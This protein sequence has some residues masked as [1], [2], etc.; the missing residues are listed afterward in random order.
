MVATPIG[1]LQDMSLRAVSI[2][3][4]ADRIICED[5]RVTG[6][7]L[8][9]FGIDASLVFYNDHSDEE[10]RQFILDELSAGKT[11][12]M[13]SDAGT[14]LI[15]DPGYKLVK[16][17]YENDI[18]V[19]AV[20]GANAP[21]TALQLSGLPSDA[22]SF[23]GFLPSK[24]K[25]RIDV[26]SKW[27]AV[28][29]TLIAFDSSARLIDSLSAAR[30][31]LG[32]RQVAV[33]REMTKLYEEARRGS[34]EELIS[35]YQDNGTPK[36]E[37]VIVIGPPQPEKF[38]Q[39]GIDALLTDALRDMRVKDA[40]TAVANKTGLSKNKLYDRALSLKDSQ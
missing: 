1:N 38:D 4:R 39:A 6:R 28:S 31:I 14:P 26:L 32:D 25:A 40:A 33:I 29:S 2:L 5:T 20:P 10:K 19:S 30:E 22:F 21:L 18:Y 36:G 34:F 12:A 35:F 13:V 17:C 16:L 11:L 23:I 9:A 15:S 7:L 24:Q 27:Q 3:S 37:I 8:K